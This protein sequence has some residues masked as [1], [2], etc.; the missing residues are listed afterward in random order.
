MHIS[1]KVSDVVLHLNSSENCIIYASN[2]NIMQ[3]TFWAD[4]MQCMYSKQ[5]IFGMTNYFSENDANI[6]NVTSVYKIKYIFHNFMGKRTWN[7]TFWC[8]IKVKMEFVIWL[9]IQSTKTKTP[10]IIFIYFNIFWYSCAACSKFKTGEIY[11]LQSGSMFSSSYRQCL[12]SGRNSGS[13]HKENYVTISMFLAYVK[14][15]KV[16]FTL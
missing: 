15:K 6:Y 1:T 8:H 9:L 12:F 13:S 10:K 16:Q 5:N 11:V 7:L 2:T 3:R 4:T 14:G